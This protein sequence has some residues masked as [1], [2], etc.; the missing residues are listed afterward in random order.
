LNW[1]CFVKKENNQIRQLFLRLSGLAV[2]FFATLRE[3]KFKRGEVSREGRKGCSQRTQK[4]Y[5]F[6]LNWL[7][8]VKKE[9]N[10]IRQLFLRL[11]GL[12]GFFLCDFA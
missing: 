2:F 8:F 4:E 7:C 3:Q 5:Q 11:S 9:N 10:Q 1:L 12:C 6:F